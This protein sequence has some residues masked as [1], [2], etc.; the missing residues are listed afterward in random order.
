MTTPNA[1][2]SAL[3]NPNRQAIFE[4]LT[5]VE[6]GVKELTAELDISQPAVSQH[7]AT[8]SEAALVLARRDGRRTYYRA[9]PQALQPIIDW[10]ALYRSFWTERVAALEDLLDGMDE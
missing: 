9:S 6:L 4:R 7:L 10:V 8:L 3:A 5:Q 1:I 2:F